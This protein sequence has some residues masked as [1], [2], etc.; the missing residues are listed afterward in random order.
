MRARRG[1]RVVVR[2]NEQARI[3]LSVVARIGGRRRT[4]GT[5]TIRLAANGRADFRLRLSRRGRALLRGQP[6]LR[7]TLSARARDARNNLGTRRR[8]GRLPLGGRRRAEAGGLAQR[9]GLV[10][11][12]PR[13][14]VVLA[15]EVAVGGGLLVDRPVEVEVLAEGA[16]AQVEVLVDEL[17]RSATA[18]IFSVPNVSTIT[19]TGC[20]TPIA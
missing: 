13:E 1:L 6:R 14:V 20:A 7:L 10:G 16:R 8:P 9:V 18:T 15:A 12:L 19:E 4:L 3:G 17:A 2:T 5:R 11:L